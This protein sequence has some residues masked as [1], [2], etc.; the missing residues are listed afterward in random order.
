MSRWRRRCR[1]WRATARTFSAGCAKSSPTGRTSKWSGDRFVLP[2]EVLFETGQASL[3][4]E[5]KAEIDKI[6]V[7]L[8]E[9]AKEIPPEIPWV[10]RVDGHTDKRPIAS[11]QFNRTGIY[12]PAAP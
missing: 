9:V 11:P 5:G 4:P 12:P 10:L 7:A 8:S 1:N 3:T 6:S 2:S